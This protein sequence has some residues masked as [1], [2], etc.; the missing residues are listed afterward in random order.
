MRYA[1]RRSIFYLFKILWVAIDRI[2]HREIDIRNYYRKYFNTCGRLRKSYSFNFKSNKIYYDPVHNGS[3]YKMYFTGEPFEKK[4]ID[5]LYDNVID[6]NSIILDIGANIGTHSVAFA[7]KAANGQV[8]SFEPSRNT[9]NILAKNV[10]N[11]RNIIPIN[12]ALSNEDGIADFYE[13]STSALSSLLNT[14]RD[15]IKAINRVLCVNGDYVIEKI[16]QPPKVDFIKIDVEG[17]E[18]LVLEGLKNTIE[19]FHPKIFCEIYKGTNSNPDPE[20]T[21][22]FLIE[23]G[24]SAF[25]FVDEELKEYESHDDKNHD[26]LFIFNPVYET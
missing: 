18:K 3:G 5:Y 19:K 16:L 4:E 13:F 1:I 12:L 7:T 25:V 23:T 11:K 6:E 17:A 24:Y 8:Y 21:I 15:K 9:F 22:N 26:Y 14:N 2:K 20:G 10:K